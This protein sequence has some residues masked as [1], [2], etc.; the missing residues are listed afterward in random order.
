MIFFEVCG[1]IFVQI[2]SNKI[3][4]L[5]NIFKYREISAFFYDIFLKPKDKNCHLWLEIEKIKK[6]IFLWI[7]RRK[8]K[9]VK[10]TGLFLAYG[11]SPGR[12]S[13]AKKP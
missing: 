4:V 12:Y 8:S 7:Q 3:Y 1:F 11:I 10:S 9:T 5:K 6:L 13:D 2:L